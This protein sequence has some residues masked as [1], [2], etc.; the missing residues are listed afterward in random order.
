MVM[1]DKIVEVQLQIDAGRRAGV[2]G[3]VRVARYA[4]AAD[5]LAAGPEPAQ[6]RQHGKPASP[7]KNQLPNTACTVLQDVERECAAACASLAM[8]RPLN[9]SLRAEDLAQL[10]QRL[11]ELLAKQTFSDIV[12]VVKR[13][14]PV[15]LNVELMQDV[16][17]ECAA[18]CASLAMPMPL[19][20][21][22]RAEDLAQLQ[23]HLSEL[24]MQPEP[25][26]PFTPSLKVFSP[27]LARPSRACDWHTTSTAIFPQGC[28]H[29]PL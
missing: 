13:K 11:S 25:A 4:H 26:V 10:Q 15:E 6:Q 5:R 14:N 18:A 23:R 21:S 12:C 8:P 17:R 20:V 22:L 28:S 7:R 27:P 3:R 1:G 29:M 16:E 9:V 2:R 24:L 19:N